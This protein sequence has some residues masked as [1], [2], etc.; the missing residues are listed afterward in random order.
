MPSVS[1]ILIV[2]LNFPRFE[3]YNVVRLCRLVPYPS[4]IFPHRP[5]LDLRIAS[6]IDML[7]S[8]PPPGYTLPAVIAS[9]SSI[10]RHHVI[11]LICREL[12]PLYPNTNSLS[13]LTASPPP[14]PGTTTNP[15]AAQRPV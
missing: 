14:S 3:I 6:S 15:I 12:L 9:N 5:F 2:L 1:S 13:P 10:A 8:R 4:P 11:A 7:F